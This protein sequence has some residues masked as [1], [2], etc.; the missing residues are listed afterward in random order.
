MHKKIETIN[1]KKIAIVY[2][3]VQLSIVPSLV[4]LIEGLAESGYEMDIFV[5]EN[6]H[7]PSIKFQQENINLHIL[8]SDENMSQLSWKL[9]YVF[10]WLPFVFKKLKAA[11]YAFIIGVDPLGLVLSYP[12]ATLLKV[13]LV[14]FSLEL[15][16][17]NELSSQVLKMLKIAERKANRSAALTIIQDIDRSKVIIQE[18]DIRANQI[19]YLP[20]AP[21]G[22]AFFKRS[23]YLRD[24]LGIASNKKIVLHS[25]SIH[26]MMLSTELVGV[27]RTWDD[28]FVMVFHCRNSLTSEYEKKWKSFVDSKKI[29]INDKPVDF[30]DLGN[31]VSSADIGIAVYQKSMLNLNLFCMGLSSGKIACYLQR[32]VP[33]IVSALPTL[34]NLVEEYKCGIAVESVTEIQAAI[35]NI[36]ADYDVYST[37]AIKC[38]REKYDFRDHFDKVRRRLFD[39]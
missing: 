39:I 7:F 26:P 3:S 2:P 33:I 34:R 36:L 25:G 32:G 29:L 10:R 35:R 14:Y 37:N 17:Q 6:A 16:I 15:L 4:G 22:E 9:N 19:E 30:E 27:A 24:H 5:C 18:N 1:K 21:T 12:T 20:N 38:F 31:I 28:D 23:N 8:G 13:P 11:D